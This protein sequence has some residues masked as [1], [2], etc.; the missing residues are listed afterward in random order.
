MKAREI[1]FMLAAAL[2]LVACAS[3]APSRGDAAAPA[4]S[5]AAVAAATSAPVTAAAA[6]APAPSTASAATLAANSKAAH[7]TLDDYHHVVSNGKDYYCKTE[8]LT[9]SRLNKQ[10]ICLTKEEW[11]G[12]RDG[13]R[14]YINGVQ[15]AANHYCARVGSVQEC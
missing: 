9:G 12:L 15:G 4:A 5:S 11:E 1:L 2:L 8:V 13:T 3:P 10:Q 7:M 14:N 6:S